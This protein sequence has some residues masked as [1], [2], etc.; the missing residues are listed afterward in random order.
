M[1]EYCGGG[2]GGSG[3]AC[4]SVD[5]CVDVLVVC[6]LVHCR[7]VAIGDV[8]VDVVVVRAGRVLSLV[9]GGGGGGGI[10]VN[11]GACVVSVF[12]PRS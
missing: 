1:C 11:V 3:G 7:G 2:C 5:S 8:C 9:G 10:C 12:A 6:V 4:G